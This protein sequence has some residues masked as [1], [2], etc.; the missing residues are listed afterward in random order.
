MGRQRALDALHLRWTDRIPKWIEVPRHASFLRTLTGIDP[1]EH[2]QEASIRAIE[3][4]DLDIADYYVSIAPPVTGGVETRDTASG[5][6]A[7]F[8]DVG[9]NGSNGGTL[10]KEEITHS[11]FTVD[12]VLSFDTRQHPLNMTLN[13]F[14]AQISTQLTDVQRRRQV[15]GDRAWPP[16]PVDWYNTVFMWGIT[17]F[18]WEPFLTAA[19]L[20]PKRYAQ[21]LE[22]FTDITARYFSAAAQLNDVV[23]AQAHDDLCMTRGPVFN[24]TWY[25]E[26]IFPLYPKV[27]RPLKEKGIK[28]IYRGDGNVDEFVD[29][30][31]A[32]GF[33]G[34]IIRSETNLARLAGKYG[35]SKII[36]GNISTA[37]LTLGSRTE[38]AAEV[39]RCADQ[40]GGCPGYFFR[41][42]GEIPGNVPI[43]NIFYLFEA[44]DQYGSR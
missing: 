5:T 7:G 10:W 23:I 36:A 29:D 1:Y 20:E 40:A 8:Y 16:D 35:G 43:D 39:K 3:R 41:V 34:F 44:L 14:E 33:D 6:V 21:L 38:I 25:R 27:L 42:A 2:P 37:I 28:V 17:T 30:L 31:A 26:Y 9:V 18:G 15:L 24:P 22:R 19:A 12:E 32:V 13:E 11:S 4:L